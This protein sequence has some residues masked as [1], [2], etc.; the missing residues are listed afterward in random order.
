MF[1]LF[2]NTKLWLPSDSFRFISPRN[3]KYLLHSPLSLPY[4]PCWISLSKGF[5]YV[6]R[7]VEF[8]YVCKKSSTFQN[9]QVEFRGE[10][11][12]IFSE[13][14]HAD[15]LTNTISPLDVHFVLFMQTTHK[16]VTQTF[17]LREARLYLYENL[18]F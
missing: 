14:K 7:R 13:M 4:S 16:N 10:F 8:L 11:V 17:S 12:E 6:P 18:K 9:V 5:A 1:I 15:R 3:Q 2:H